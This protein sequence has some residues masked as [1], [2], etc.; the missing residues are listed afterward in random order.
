MSKQKVYSN[1]QMICSFI[2]TFGLWW[3][4]DNF[5]GKA[6]MNIFKEFNQRPLELLKIVSS[7]CLS[8]ICALLWS[9]D[10]KVWAL[11]T[12]LRHQ[13]SSVLNITSVYRHW[14]LLSAEHCSKSKDNIYN[15]RYLLAQWVSNPFQW[16]ECIHKTPSNI[17]NCVSLPEESNEWALWI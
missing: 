9:L 11:L 3:K 5:S 7:S 13:S 16:A 14:F 12:L 15:N 2:S 1:C 8:I 6:S 4:S 17:I 10:L